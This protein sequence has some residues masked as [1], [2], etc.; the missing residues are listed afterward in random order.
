MV[1]YDIHTHQTQ[2]ASGVISIVNKLV[3][4]Q[5]SFCFLPG[6]YYSYGIHPWHIQDK[7]MQL[8]LLTEAVLHPSVVALGEA[9]LDKNIETPL[10]LQKEVFAEQVKLAEE[11][12]KPLIIHC[13]KAWDELLA[14]KK[15]LNPDMPW[16]IHG[17]RGNAQLAEQLINKGFR[18]SFGE[19]YNPEALRIAWPDHIFAET[20][21]SDKSIQEIYDDHAKS[22]NISIDLLALTLSKNVK[23]VFSV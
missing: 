5:H 4:L 14:I 11:I 3:D 13:V 2:T 21:E 1:Y 16:I 12:G 18:L 15:E 20:D 9:G 17:F 8:M 10:Q 6:C 19:K 23:E 7:D 22:L